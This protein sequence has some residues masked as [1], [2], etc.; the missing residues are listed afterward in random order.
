MRAFHDEHATKGS[1]VYPRKV[2]FATY[3]LK[4]NK[5]GWVAI[6]RMIE[7]YRR[8]TV[9]GEVEGEMATLRTDNVAVIAVAREVGEKLRLD[10]QEFPLREAVGGL[11]PDVYFRKLDK[12]WEMLDHDGSLAIQKND[13]G[14]KHPGLQGPID[15]A[16]DA[17]FLCVRG[18][19]TPN[20]PKV[21]AWAD[22]RL[23]RFAADWSRFLRG[24]VRIKKDVDVTEQDIEEH[25]LILFGDPGSNR[26]IAR[27]LPE[28][29]MTW[30]AAEVGI[31]EN[32]PATDHAPVLIGVNPLNRLRYVVINSGH[33]FGAREFN[34]T[35]A[36][37]YPHLGDHAV[38]KIGEADEVKA[39]GYFN[40][41][42]KT[43]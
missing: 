37:L 5:A 25:H 7:H 42:W 19:G 13:R 33:T 39:G 9:E 12:G 18:T 11:L 43:R 21:Q 16:F 27:V 32:F 22:A 36:L 28:L 38:I 2:R 30:T 4:Y 41:K 35:N 15:D 23:D 17:P 10:G 20:N 31:V 8:A 29:P 24:E 26:L 34:G 6:Q 14:A 40:E 3:T 1:E